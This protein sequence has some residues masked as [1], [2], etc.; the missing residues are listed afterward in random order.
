[1]SV[2]IIIPNWNGRNLLEKNL[3]SIINASKNKKNEIRE[4]IVVDDASSDDSVNFLKRNYSKDIKLVVHK[5]N[6]GFAA[7]VNTGVRSAK[8][9]YVVLLNS[10]IIVLDN[11]LEAPLKD[12]ESDE[13]IFAISLH[14][15]GYGSA[16]GLFKNGFIIH[17]GLSETKDKQVTFWASGGSAIFRKDIWKGLHGMDEELYSPF[18][19]EDIDLSYRAQKRGYKILWEPN[20]HVIHE[21]EATMKRL[22]QNKVN[23]IRERNYLLFNWKNITSPNL[24][25]KHFS[26]LFKRIVRHPGYLKVV[27]SAL[28]KYSI[29]KKLQA[30]EKKETKVSDEAIFARFN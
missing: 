16:K 9:K 12:L 3:S 27:F 15:K 7:S 24:K 14:E 10:D 21:H 18:Y 11:F 26:G 19:W 5:I 17:E 2:S 13:N 30:R 1:M 4:I 28:K 6:R 23:R 25:R 8:G 29:V 20:A 22:P